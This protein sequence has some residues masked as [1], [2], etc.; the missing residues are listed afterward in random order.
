[1]TSPAAARLYEAQHIYAWSGK[2]L[3][4]YNPL[5]KP[6]DELPVIYGF[7]NGGRPGLLHARLLSEDGCN[8]GSHCC[9]TEAY[10]PHD[11]GCLEGSRPD[12]HEDF[13][14]KYPDG[15]RMEFVGYTEVKT[16]QALNKAFELSKLLS[17]EENT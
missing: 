12:R 5:G 2:S 14:K 10:M 6:V 17:I 9:S 16:H 15:Y 3:A 4:V 13:Q 7:N 8:M 11:L 1:M